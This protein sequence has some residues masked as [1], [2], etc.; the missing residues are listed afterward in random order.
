MR[1]VE[2]RYCPVWPVKKLIAVRVADELR[3]EKGL[4]VGVVKG[5]LLELSIYVDGEKA[6]ETSRLWYPAPSRMVTQALEF[7]GKH[8]G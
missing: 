3:K 8:H 4:E 2:I 1:K 5:G 6:V 7:L